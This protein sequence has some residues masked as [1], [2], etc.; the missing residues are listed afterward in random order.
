MKKLLPWLT[1]AIILVLIFGTIYVVVQQDQRSDANQPQIELAEDTAT[2]LANAANPHS[3]V[4]GRVDIVNS[5]APFILIYNRSGHIV[6]GN[7]YY[8]GVLPQAPIG[9]LQSSNGKPYSFVTWQ[10]STSVRIAAVSVATNSYYVVSGRSLT[11]VE[12][13][14]TKTLLLSAF[15]GFAALVTLG[16]GCIWYTAGPKQ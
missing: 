8:Y 3:L 12:K 9:F 11:E 1:A 14:E 16:V 2:Q 10:P 6:A 4:S 7:G 15:G 5:L 13:N